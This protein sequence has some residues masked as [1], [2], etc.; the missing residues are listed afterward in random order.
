M[1]SAYAVVC[2]VASLRGVE[3]FLLDLAGL[4]RYWRPERKEYVI[5]PLL[6]KIKGESNDAAHLIPCVPVTSSGIDMKYV[7]ERLIKAKESLGLRD[8]PAISEETGKLLESR[9]IDDMLTELLI[10][11]YHEDRNLFPVDV[12][13]EDKIRDNYQCFRTFRRTSDTR[14][15]EKKVSE[16][17]VDIVNRWKTLETDEGSRPG[18]PMRQHYAQ[19]D[20]LMK[21]FLQYT[22]A[23]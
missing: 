17:D 21:H 1:F 4:I 10:N 16:S 19:L 15:L 2:Y 23:M 11:C 9:E 5:I 7:L 18:R 13:T 12:D 3:G 8:G 20:L 22:F 6:G 14:A